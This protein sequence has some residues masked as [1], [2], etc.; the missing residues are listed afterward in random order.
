MKARLINKPVKQPTNQ[1]NKLCE[2]N[3][4]QAIS[5]TAS[6]SKMTSKSIRKKENIV[7]NIEMSN[8]LT[9]ATE[10]TPEE[11]KYV[12]EI[13]S[14]QP[15]VQSLRV[16]Y[17]NSE[18]VESSIKVKNEPATV[19]GITPNNFEIEVGQLQTVNIMFDKKFPSDQQPPK[20]LNNDEAINL[21]DTDISTNQANARFAVTGMEVGNGVIDCY[22]NGKNHPITYNVVDKKTINSNTHILVKTNLE[23]SDKEFI[24]NYMT[25]V[26]YTPNQNDLI[27][28]KVMEDVTIFAIK[29]YIYSNNEWINMNGI[30]S[31][32][33][34]IFDDDL[35]LAGDY[36]SIG[37]IKKEYDGQIL[38][39]KGTSVLSFIK[40]LL[41][42][43]I[44][45]SVIS[46]PTLAGFDH[47]KDT[48]YEYGTILKDIRYGNQ[49]VFKQGTYSFNQYS[50]VDILNCI[51]CRETAL[52][53]DHIN[54]TFSGLDESVLLT[55]NMKYLKYS[56][57][58][59]YSDDKT[60]LL[61]NLG[62]FA[63]NNANIKSNTF[64]VTSKTIL[65]Y[66]KIF[67][68]GLSQDITSESI[69]D[70][71]FIPNINI[72][73]ELKITVKPN[74]KYVII[75]YPKD[76][77]KIQKIINNTIMGSDVT[78]TFNHT[79]LKV[80]G[81]NNYLPIDYDIYM[82]SPANPFLYDTE[83]IVTLGGDTNE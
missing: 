57:E 16:A 73:N 14:L 64:T 53:K 72:P 37:N 63:T 83:F 35:I 68:G 29:T 40:D 77:F 11:D 39:V 46:Y 13:K 48:Q 42:K 33:D 8:G 36:N 1:E 5:A 59:T 79:I 56:A 52:S 45:P 30:T 66:R 58:I 24:N 41:M 78:D 22:V 49:A 21:S 61:D 7:L 67:F 17:L 76:Q 74:S 55:E 6:D 69:R 4:D 44:Q 19:L 12:A 70:L 9:Q 47:N 26:N 18:P 3:L 62:N 65:G 75:A 2:I 43:S 15:G 23:I 50:N 10:F 31:A 60:Q 25:E 54:S 32:N 80:A 81:E 28:I 34:V 71:D 82:Y 51:I 27:I 20:I 38:S